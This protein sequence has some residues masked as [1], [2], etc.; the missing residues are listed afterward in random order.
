ML[1]VG[2]K[3]PN[4][5]ARLSELTALLVKL[6]CSMSP[7]EKAYVGYSVAEDNTIL[8]ELQPYRELDPSRLKLHGTGHWDATPFLPDNL[9]MAYREPCTIGLDRVPEVWEYPA[10]RDPPATIAD[11]ARVWDANGLLFLHSAEA[12]VKPAH[13]LVR[14]F[15]CYKS[16]DRD[17]QI[18][19]R[20]GRNAVECKVFGPSA[21]LPSGPDLCELAID[22]KTQRIALSIS[23]RRDFYHQFWVTRRKAVHNTLGPGTVL[24]N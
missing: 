12:R 14:I 1:H 11:L 18:G 8:P 22:L 21:D 24:L 16:A 17:T 20:R 7:Y 2:R 15:N 10:L 19:D 9:V 23:D 4:L 3:N 13:E 5:I 6:G